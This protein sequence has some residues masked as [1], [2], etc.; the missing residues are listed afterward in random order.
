MFL[1]LLLVS[2]LIA[3]SLSYGQQGGN[4]G[5]GFV[6]GQPTGIA[7]KYRMNNSNA[8]DGIVGVGPYDRFRLQADYLWESHPFKEKNLLLHY[9]PGVAFG[10]GQTEY[11]V[12]Y[13]KGVQYLTNEEPRFGVR[14]VVGLS[15]LINK[16]P[17]DIFFELAPVVILEP[18]LGSGFDLGFGIRAYP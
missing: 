18:G 2:V 17:L 12:H 10:F 9:G 6:F 1:K 3:S 4:F 15:Y 14:G 5:I 16:T 8:L 11:V 7:W 13:D